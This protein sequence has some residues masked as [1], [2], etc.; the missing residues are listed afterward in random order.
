MYQVNVNMSFEFTSSLYKKFLWCALCV[1]LLWDAINYPFLF[2]EGYRI[3]LTLLAIAT[4]GIALKISILVSLIRKKGPIKLLVGIWGALMITSGLFGFIAILLAAEP[5]G[6][7]I[8]IEKSLI[9]SFGLGLVW[10]M[11]KSIRS[12]ENA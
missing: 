5:Q 1:V 9:F 7:S 3:P 4:I 10:P 6:V 12:I 11:S 2:T 8:I